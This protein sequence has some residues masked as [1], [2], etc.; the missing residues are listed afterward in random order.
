MVADA[1]TSENFSCIKVCLTFN[2]FLHGVNQ[3]VFLLYSG[4]L[5]L[6]V[7]SCF[8]GVCNIVI[9]C[10][11]ICILA[12]FLWIPEMV[13]WVHAIDRNSQVVLV[14]RHKVFLFNLAVWWFGGWAFW[15]KPA[16]EMLLMREFWQIVWIGEYTVLDTSRENAFDT[17][18]G[19]FQTCFTSLCATFYLASLAWLA[20]STTLAHGLR[21]PFTRYFCCLVLSSFATLL[22]IEG[23][24]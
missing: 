3:S 13:L 19:T 15:F 17:F 6:L 5:G 10:I 4:A 1:G 16:F 12:F 11:I 2:S 23:A 20:T 24:S 21:L 7:V 22:H 14:S 18:L 8:I 9:I